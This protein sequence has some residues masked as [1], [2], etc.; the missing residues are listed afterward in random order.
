MIELLFV[1]SITCFIGLKKN[2]SDA[3][4]NYWRNIDKEILFCFIALFILGL[5]F[6]FSSTSTLAG[7]RLNKDYYFFFTKH[8]IFSISSLLLMIFISNIDL[9][10][11]NNL[12]IGN[13]NQ[14]LKICH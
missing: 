14:Q 4:H 6:S 2:L 11:F 10:I 13:K 1:R 7:E 3:I 8:F 9:K 12:I 5:F